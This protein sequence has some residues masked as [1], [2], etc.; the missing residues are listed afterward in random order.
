MNFGLSSKEIHT[1]Q[2]I[3]QMHTYVKYSFL[4]PARLDH[5]HIVKYM[6]NTVHFPFS[7]HWA[8]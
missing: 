4:G 6:V 7:I 1:L 3:L 5:E 2:D 8:N